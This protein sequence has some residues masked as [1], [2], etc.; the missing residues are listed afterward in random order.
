[1]A[2]KKS[3]TSR[4]YVD[5]KKLNDEMV[6]YVTAYRE[7][8]EKGEI[9]PRIPEYIGECFQLIAD[10]LG[11]KYNFRGYSYLEE[12]KFDGILDC[13]KYCHNF[14]IDKYNRPFSYF[15]RIIWQAFVR[16]IASEKKEQYT[17]YKLSMNRVDNIYVTE[18][19]AE[20]QEKIAE[21]QEKY[22][23]KKKD[24]V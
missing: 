21:L 16:R 19:S 24:Q 23:P 8:K 9:P 17:K 7:A 14:N 2:R 10:G 13:V 22:E 1:M 3:D 6:K 11:E 12:M 18:H 20:I 15:S 4:H 5:N